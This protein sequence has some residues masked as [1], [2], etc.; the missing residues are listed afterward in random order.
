MTGDSGVIFPLIILIVGAFVI[1]LLAR[2]LKLSNRVE[3][4]LTVLVLGS[5]L[6]VTILM[7]PEWFGSVELFFGQL[8]Y[9][10]VV[11]QPDIL[12]VFVFLV[13]LIMGILVCLYS[14]EYL[15][16]DSRYLVYYPLILL[17]LAGLLGMFFTRD[18]FNLFLL[19]ELTAITA[20]ALI[21]F[22]YKQI[23]AIQAGFKYLIMSSLGTMV[24]L[25][26]IY[27]V[28][29]GS[30][31]LRIVAEMGGRT[32]GLSKIGGACFFLGFSLKAGI[33][34][35]HTWV[36]DVYSQ[37]PS[38]I[39]GLLAGVLSKSM[40]FFIPWVCLA[41]GMTEQELGLMMVISACLNMLVGVIH[42][43]NQREVRRFL[44]YSSIAQT[45]YLMFILGIGVYY[46]STTAYFAGI[47]LFLGEAMMNGLVFLAAGVYEY[48]LGIQDIHQLRGV[49]RVLPWQAFCFSIGLAGLSGIPLLAGFTG[50]WLVFSAAIAVND[51]IAWG[52]L[53]VFLLS[54]LI[55]LGGFLPVLV[56]QYQGEKSEEDPVKVKPDKPRVSGWMAV[57]IGML[58]V[59][60]ILLGVYPDPWVGMIESMLE[61]L[62]L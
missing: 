18:L 44:S 13:A 61:W 42:A 49:N 57:P 23:R 15:S 48:H 56:R 43:L 54:T 32:D 35:L 16:R 3:A 50:K 11:F 58:T 51:W 7:I 55:G 6:V 47:F 37:A 39:S 25:L 10:G 60:V 40:L 14:G 4:I 9:G 34:P 27:F 28:Y 45:G 8:G 22:R 20:S 59:M 38:A 52:G 33:V 19:T 26:G 41:L 36:P 2:L 5:T 31:D 1:Y 30:G 46:Q 17:L 21:G 62:A 24:V 29:R 53:V 12:G